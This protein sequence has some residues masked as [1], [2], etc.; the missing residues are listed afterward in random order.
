MS[1][2]AAPTN[3]SGTYSGYLNAPIT[4][5][6]STGQYPGIIP[7]NNLGGLFG[8]RPTPP[9]FYSQQE[10]VYADMNTNARQQ[11]KR[12]LAH[13]VPAQFA[14]R[15]LEQLVS[16]T[17]LKY[18]T[19]TGHGYAV[20][21]NFNYIEPVPSSMYVDIK[22]SYAVGK[23]SYKVGLPAQTPISTKNYYPSGVRSSLRRARSGGSVAPKKKGAIENTSLRNGRINSWGS[24]VRSDY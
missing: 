6:L 17:T 11:Y 20:S 8:I 15:G 5:P 1:R 10:P 21:Q 19:S 16:P 24:I 9:Q 23:S 7:K 18:V 3:F 13:T 22:K 14:A 12:A 2:P 4:G